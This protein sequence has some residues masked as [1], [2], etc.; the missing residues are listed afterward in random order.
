[1]VTGSDE[2]SATTG[3][4]SPGSTFTPGD[5]ILKV[6]P[7]VLMFYLF[8]AVLT[9]GGFLAH[10]F[11][12]VRDFFHFRLRLPDLSFLDSKA[13]AWWWT[14]VLAPPWT[15]SIGAIFVLVSGAV[16][17]TFFLVYWSIYHTFHG[18]E[19]DYYSNTEIAARVV[20]QL[21]NVWL[22]LML[23]P[24]SKNSILT[25]AFGIAWEQVIYVHVWMGNAFMALC[26]LHMFLWWGV[27]AD[28]EILQNDI[29]SVPQNFPCNGPCT[30][31]NP[32]GDNWTISMM[33]V[34]VWA[35]FIFMGVF[36]RNAVR[37]ANFELFY[38]SHH[39]FL[40]IFI[41]VSWHASS[42]HYFL[43]GGAGLFIVDR[44]LRALNR[45]R[46][47]RVASITVCPDTITGLE[48]EPLD[49]F[50][51]RRSQFQYS[52]GQYLYL[53]IPEISPL[54]WHPFTISSAPSDRRVT[55]HIKQAPAGPSTFTGKL[56][57][58]AQNSDQDAKQPFTVNVDGPYG[59]WFDH[60][61]YD[62]VTLVAGGIGVTPCM[63]IFR[64]L[65]LQT[66]SG[67]IRPGTLEQVNLVWCIQKREGLEPFIDV[68]RAAKAESPAGQC[69]FNFEIFIDNDGDFGSIEH[70]GIPIKSGR[71]DCNSLISDL[72][73]MVSE[74]KRPH[75]FACGPP[76]MVAMVNN[77]CLTHKISFHKEVFAF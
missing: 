74:G 76:G 46:R 18:S 11:T 45:A 72:G 66:L 20:G 8:L 15:I 1:M 50:M 17:L 6:Y 62:I 60:T 36:A 68:L 12:T 52:C 27:Y 31:N 61:G 55:C 63:S 42:A 53:N 41:G 64:E 35:M 43:I 39:F 16:F 54:E 65:L 58:L 30:P 19:N 47:W 28:L 32:H 25:S 4:D 34:I 49:D 48:L 51:G 26:A 7:D 57:Q 73:G 67:T 40:V 33:T 9:V 69:V 59:A 37:R 38:Y 44:C 29:L 5:L 77:A 70:L 21:A 75:V 23:F 24:V 22:G 10:T 13:M 56:F 2:V 3:E 14:W 71:P